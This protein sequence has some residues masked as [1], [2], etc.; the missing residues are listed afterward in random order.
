MYPVRLNCW[1]H[2]S[3]PTGKLSLVHVMFLLSIG[4]LASPTK[5]QTMIVYFSEINAARICIVQGHFSDKPSTMYS[6]GIR[7]VLI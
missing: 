2:T 6:S 5:S 4:I 1:R 3:D 7:K